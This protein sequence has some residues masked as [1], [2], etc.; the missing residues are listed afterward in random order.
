MNIRE[1]TLNDAARIAEIYNTYLGISTMDLV[2]YTNES[3]SFTLSNQANKEKFFVLEDNSQV[4]GWGQIKKYSDR[5]GYK[6]ACETAVY[7]DED[8][9]GK[10][11][12]TTL[13]Q[14]VIH[15]C[16]ELG[17]KHLV[18]KIQADNTVSIHYNEKLG[19]RI[20][21]KQNRIGFVNGKWK[22]VIIMELLFT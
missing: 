11:H 12:G 20:V 13:K 21:G 19:Y 9:L 22:D 3:V 7:L 5:E 17:Y 18:A 2:P 6:F 4:I 1:A 15:A 10:G 14:H 16:K 8:Y